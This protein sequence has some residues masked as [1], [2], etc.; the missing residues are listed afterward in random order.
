[1]G[2]DCYVENAQGDELWYGRKENEIH[3]WMQ[4]KSGIP[5]EDFN[6]VKFKLTKEILEQFLEDVNNKKLEHARGFFFGSANDYDEI[7]IAAENLFKAAYPVILEGEFE[8]YYT[9]WW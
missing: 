8:V 9:S 1:M 5:V 3:G 6:C 2:L 7:K 4:K